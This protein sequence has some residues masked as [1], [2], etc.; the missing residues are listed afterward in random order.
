MA[1]R[2]AADAPADPQ[3]L[4]LA[5]SCRWRVSGGFQKTGSMLRLTVRLTEVLTNHDV[6][7]EEVD[8]S[9]EALFEMQERVAAVVGEKLNRAAPLPEQKAIPKLSAYECYVKGQ[10]AWLRMEKESL[11]KARESFEQAVDLD[12]TYASALAGMAMVNALGHTYTSDPALLDVA[13]DYARRAIAADPTLAEPHAQLAYILM[14]W[15]KRSESY[16]EAKRAIELDPD[17]FMAWYFGAAPLSIPLPRR[18]AEK[19][20][21]RIPGRGETTDPHRRRR[22][23]ALRMQQ[24]AIELNPRQGWAWLGAGWMHLDLGNF[25]ESRWCMEK[26]LEL[27]QTAQHSTAGVEGCLGEL[28]RR[29]GELAEARQRCLAGIEA[30]EKSDHVYRDT[31]R[32]AFL[33]SL[34]RTALQQEDSEAASA[35]FNQSVLHLRGRSRARG[36]G[37]PFVQALCGLAQIK[38][39]QGAFDEALDL[40][41]RREGFDFNFMWCCS[42]D[43]TLLAL[44]RAARGLDNIKLA[45]QLLD[46]AIDV[47]SAEAHSEV[48]T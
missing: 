10:Q 35:A 31:L 16:E 18:E 5:L 9:I 22:L 17:N 21:Q 46:E 41:R 33:C 1:A 38:K 20:C 42:D 47:G 28:L 27:E 4:G 15:G 19:L 2:Q 13:A 29:A 30:V 43:V 6:L 45:R 11:Q 32:G 39:E 34:G 8:G 24:R 40:F 26:A 25:R 23:E 37:H 12:P 48:I 44:A 3:S 36:G 14:S 7:T